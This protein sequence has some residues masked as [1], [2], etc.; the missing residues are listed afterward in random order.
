MKYLV[1]LKG[2]NHRLQHELKEYAADQ[3]FGFFTTRVVRAASEKDAAAE[4]LR[5]VDK[6]LRRMKL[7][8][9]ATRP[10]TVIVE[11]ARPVETSSEATGGGF[12]WYP[13]RDG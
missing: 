7:E 2:E 5:L 3:L 13:Q 6:E 4:A 11:W 12:T 8:V 10:P 1:R 9:S